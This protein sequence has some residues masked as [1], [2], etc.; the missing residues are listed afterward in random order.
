MKD[1][2]NHKP[3]ADLHWTDKAR[4]ITELSIMLFGLILVAYLLIGAING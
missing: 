2:V 3:Q 1:Y 4:V